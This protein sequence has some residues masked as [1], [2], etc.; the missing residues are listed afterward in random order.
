VADVTVDATASDLY[1][2]LWNR[3]APDAVGVEG[4]PGVL[5]LWRDAVQVR[6]YE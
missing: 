4:D 6:W 3:L 2:L 5:E 1:L